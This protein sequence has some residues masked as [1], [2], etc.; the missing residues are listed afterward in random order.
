VGSWWK[1]SFVVLGMQI[2]ELRRGSRARRIRQAISI[3]H[4]VVPQA[5]EARIEICGGIPPRQGW[6]RPMA[7]PTNIGADAR[8]VTHAVI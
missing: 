1:A 3:D 5:A 6:P 4:P 2:R 7:D 8:I